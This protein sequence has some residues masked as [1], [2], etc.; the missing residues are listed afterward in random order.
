MKE[1]ATHSLNTSC[2]PILIT[3]WKWLRRQSICFQ[4]MLV[5]PLLGAVLLTVLAGKMAIALMGTTRPIYAWLAGGIGGAI[6]V[7]LAKAGIAAARDQR[8]AV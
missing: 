3:M 8:R 4:A 5:V 1:Q 7:V 6:S 2:S